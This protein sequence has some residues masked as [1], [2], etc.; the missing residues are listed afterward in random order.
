MSLRWAC[1]PVLALALATA[2]CGGSDVMSA[3]QLRTGAARV[4]TVTAQ[5]LNRIPTPQIPSEGAVFLRRGIAAVA[6]EL[7]ALSAMHPDGELGVHFRQAV[8]ATEQELK[9]LQSSL[10][11]LK[12]GNDPIVA[13]KTLQ[14]QLAPLEA[15]S[16]AAWAALGVPGCADT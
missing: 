3:H 13:I 16:R 12:A 15:K 9:V 8:S 6:P 4:C 14:V 10:R 7:A 1:V 2:G 11:G 5:R